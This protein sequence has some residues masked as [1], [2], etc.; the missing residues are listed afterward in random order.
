M[1]REETGSAKQAKA[2][3]ISATMNSGLIT[4]TLMD[5]MA[6][7]PCAGDKRVRAFIM[8]TENAKKTPAI[9]PQPRADTSVRAVSKFSIIWQTT[10]TRLPDTLT[11]PDTGGGGRSRIVG[12]IPG[13]PAQGPLNAVR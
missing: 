1:N 8:K 2:V 12:E 9:N 6:A 5:C 3:P 4:T 11:V 7:I 10:E 13:L